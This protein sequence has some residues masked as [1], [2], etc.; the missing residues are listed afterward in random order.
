M[1]GR[2]TFRELSPY[3]D[4]QPYTY[5]LVSFAFSTNFFLYEKDFTVIETLLIF[6]S[7]MDISEIMTDTV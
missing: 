7:F 1:E 4:C 6:I 5:V 3:T 2:Y